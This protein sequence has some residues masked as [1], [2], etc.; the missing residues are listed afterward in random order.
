MSSYPLIY[1]IKNGYSQSMVTLF[2]HTSSPFFS[3][4]TF[5][6][7]H[8]MFGVAV[9]RLWQSMAGVESHRPV[10]RRHGAADAIISGGY[11]WN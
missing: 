9:V 7:Y 3:Q 11:V 10:E 4:L 8:A 1:M 2:S 6:Q 5:V